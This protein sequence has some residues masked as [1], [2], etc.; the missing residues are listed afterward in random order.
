MRPPSARF[1][2]TCGDTGDAGIRASCRVVIFTCGWPLTSSRVSSAR[3]AVKLRATAFAMVAAD[4]ACSSSTEIWMM[5]VSAAA[6][7]VTFGASESAVASRP[8]WAM[9]GSSTAGVA[10]TS[11]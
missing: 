8:S 7:A 4:S 2:G 1:S 10:T 5:T 11:A 6:V 9:T 3:K